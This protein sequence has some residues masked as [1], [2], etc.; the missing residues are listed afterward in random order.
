MFVCQNL[1]PIIIPNCNSLVY[2]NNV[3]TVE[4]ERVK[5]CIQNGIALAGGGTYLLSLPLPVT[6]G[7]LQALSEPTGCGGIIEWSLVGNTDDLSGILGSFG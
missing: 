2:P 3:L 5:G 1:D 4:G 6:I 7:I